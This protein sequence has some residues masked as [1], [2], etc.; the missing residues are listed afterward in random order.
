MGPFHPG[1]CPYSVPP[2]WGPVSWCLSVYSSGPFNLGPNPRLS[3]PSK[4]PC[5][6]TGLQSWVPPSAPLQLWDA[7]R[8]GL[9]ASLCPPASQTLSL[10]AAP[11]P[12]LCLLCLPRG[13]SLGAPEFLRS[14]G[15]GP[16][17]RGLVADYIGA[18]CGCLFLKGTPGTF[19]SNF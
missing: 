12:D 14:P 19:T 2:S 10:G 7:S 11:T 17:P 13:S 16:S 4:T 3:P 6:L 5:S 1:P 8:R 9:L 15:S 18:W